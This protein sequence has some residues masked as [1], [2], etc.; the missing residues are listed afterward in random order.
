MPSAYAQMFRDELRDRPLDRVILGAFAEV[1]RAHG[2]GRGAD[3][4]C[5]PGRIT[6]HLEESGLDA[7]GVD[8]SPAMIEPARRAHPHLRFAV[9]S[10]TALDI[11]DGVLSRW[12]ASRTPPWE[13]P[14]VPAEFRR[15]PAPG[16]H[17]L[18]GFPAGDGPSRP[19]Q[20]FDHAVAPAH[21]WWPDHPAA[22]LREAGP[23]EAARTVREPQ[24]TGRR[25][26]QEVHLLARKA[27]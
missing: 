19:T 8:V 14:V 11:A 3:L 9:G 4:G 20:V 17:L 5:G 21:R 15:V 27:R 22:M 16:G 12:S 7:F 24:P 1:V 2:D 13:L 6:A 18:I 10:T 23:A 25:Q 26:F